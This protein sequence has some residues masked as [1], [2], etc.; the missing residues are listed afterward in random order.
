MVQVLVPRWDAWDHL[1][2]QCTV[3]VYVDLK[4]DSSCYLTA[5]GEKTV[6]V[7]NLKYVNREVDV[8]IGWD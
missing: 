5:R 6:T 3:V 4:V 8:M 2:P 1:A 7:E